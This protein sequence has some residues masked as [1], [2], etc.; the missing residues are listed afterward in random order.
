MRKKAWLLLLISLLFVGCTGREERSQTTRTTETALVGKW[1]LRESDGV[2]YYVTFHPSHQLSQLFIATDG[3]RRHYPGQWRMS[4]DTI[5]IS[6][7]MQEYRLVV[8]EA[9]DSVITLIRPDSTAMILDRFSDPD[10]LLP[11][12]EGLQ[13]P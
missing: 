9:S 2:S 13:F 8:T 5:F 1:E 11:E 6:D 10:D 7:R 4:G 3:Y 12:P